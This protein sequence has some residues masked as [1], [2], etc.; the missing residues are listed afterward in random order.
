MAN[1]V[2]LDQ[3]V[4]FN[5]QLIALADIGVPIDCGFEPDQSIQDALRRLNADLVSKT[6]LGKSV[7]TVFA[8]NKIAA[9]YQSA[10]HSWAVTDNPEIAFDSVSAPARE[11]RTIGMEIGHVALYPLTVLALAFSGF[12]FFCAYLF[13]KFEAMYAQV[14]DEPSATIRF[15]YTIRNTMPIWLVLA[16]VLVIV[17]VA[18]LLRAIHRHTTLIPGA[19]RYFQLRRG[20]RQAERAA[21]LIERGDDVAV[22]TLPQLDTQNLPL[23]SW[24]LNNPATS[25]ATDISEQADASASSQP[26]MLRSVAKFYRGLARQ[27][28]RIWRLT[29]PT[30]AGVLIGGAVVFVYAMSL[31]LP[32]TEL[33]HYV[34]QQSLAQLGGR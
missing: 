13:P 18:L 2:S 6:R 8:D 5:D 27:Q 33:M 32:L 28:S 10:L 24:V 26:R 14:W 25:S 21:L 30:V 17:V 20:A 4:Q 11:R 29:L 22:T 1:E 23:L 15:L 16:P 31:F 7:E 12:V 3:A 34:S 19:A 9:A